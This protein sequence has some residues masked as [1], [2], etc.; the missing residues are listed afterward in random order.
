MSVPTRNDLLIM[1]GN[2]RTTLL[3]FRVG[4]KLPGMTKPLSQDECLAL[5]WFDAAINFLNRDGA[6]K[7]DYLAKNPVVT[8]FADSFPDSEDDCSNNETEE[9]PK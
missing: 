7:P 5:A 1:I 9:I 4:E 2:A 6:F 8:D 3:D